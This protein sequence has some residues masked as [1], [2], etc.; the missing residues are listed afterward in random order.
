[1]V[2]LTYNY[3]E[4]PATKPLPFGLLDTVGVIE[5]SD[6]HSAW[7]VE[8]EPNYC[9][10]ALPYPAQCDNGAIAAG[11]VQVSVAANRVATLTLA[12]VPA[13]AYPLTVDWGDGS[14]QSTIISG[15]TGTHT[16]ANA[17]TYVMNVTGSVGYKAGPYSVVVPTSTGPTT[18][19]TWYS[20]KVSV[21]GVSLVTCDPFIVY[22]MHTCRT[23]GEVGREQE[24]ARKALELGEGRAVEVA[25]RTKLSAAAVDVTTTPGTAMDLVD[26]LASLER[27]AGIKYGGQP[28]IHAERSTALQLVSREVAF[29][30]G[31]QL[32]TGIGTPL[33]AG[34]GYADQTADKPTTSAFIYATGAMRVERSKVHDTS[35]HPPMV[36]ADNTLTSMAERLYLVGWECVVAKVQVKTTVCCP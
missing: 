21:D 31:S 7:G 26:G 18:G 30:A 24:R 8:F 22:H 13:P 6:P 17:G 14:S 27:Y 16:Y 15:T 9:G 12:G 28:V 19:A 5:E 4:A 33:V 11:T 10:P 2:A 1:M 36:S 34:A 29:V 23:V 3:V 35:G 32:Q 25:V 20:T